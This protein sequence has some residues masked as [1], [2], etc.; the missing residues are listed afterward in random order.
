MSG[1][2]NKVLLRFAVFGFLIFSPL[3]SAENCSWLSWGPD[4]SGNISRKLCEKFKPSYITLYNNERSW[5]GNSLEGF[6]YSCRNSEVKK[7]AFKKKFFGQD[8]EGSSK[9]VGLYSDSFI[10]ALEVSDPEKAEE[11][12]KTRKKAFDEFVLDAVDR[13]YSRV[14]VYEMFLV[15]ELCRKSGQEQIECEKCLELTAKQAMMA[16]ADQ[17]AGEKKGRTPRRFVRRFCAEHKKR[18]AEIG[19][20]IFAAKDY[21]QSIQAK[22]RPALEQNPEIENWRDIDKPGSKAS[23]SSSMASDLRIFVGDEEEPFENLLL[24]IKRTQTDY[25]Y[26]AFDYLVANPSSD[27]ETLLSRRELVRRLVEDDELYEKTRDALAKMARS[28]S[29]VTSFLF[30]RHDCFTD[31]S[32]WLYPEGCTPL[33]IFEKLGDFGLTPFKRIMEAVNRNP[34]FITVGKPLRPLGDIWAVAAP[35]FFVLAGKRGLLK[36]VSDKGLLKGGKQFCKDKGDDIAD[37]YRLFISPSKEDVA[38]GKAKKLDSPNVERAKFVA[39]CFLWAF[40]GLQGALLTTR[41]TRNYLLG[42]ADSLDSLICSGANA[43]SI[44][45]SGVKTTPAVY[46]SAKKMALGLSD[47]VTSCRGLSALMA[48]NPVG[49]G[50][51]T[52]LDDLHDFVSGHNQEIKPILSKLESC[53]ASSSRGHILSTIREAYPIRWFF[54]KPLEAVGQI[55]AFVAA[56]TLVREHRK[57][58]GNGFCFADFRKTKTPG[59]RISDFW[60]PYINSEEA[61][62]NSLS[63]GWGDSEK[64][65]LL[66]GPNGGG[67][68]TLLRAVATCILMGQVFGISP[69]KSCSFSIYDLFDSC[70]ATK[71]KPADKRSLFMVQSDEVNKMRQVISAA[72]HAGKLAFVVI[73]EIYGGTGEES[74][75]PLGLAFGQEVTENPSSSVLLSSHFWNM[76]V[77][78]SMSNGIFKNFRVIKEKAEGDSGRIKLTYKLAEGRPD[79]FEDAVGIQVAQNCGTDEFFIGKAKELKQ[80]LYGAKKVSTTS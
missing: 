13:V 37:Q 16:L 24:R 54:S 23:L 6:I 56:A 72:N 58:G 19:S 2:Y 3:S 30:E 41:L 45:R 78:E 5:Y 36:Y 32:L 66:C 31:K 71:D 43:K 40:T 70:M 47:F 12:K 68:S 76:G 75:V 74:A 42:P 44:Y 1:F 77:L 26:A 53:K 14:C 18:G 57:K 34:L 52:L 65:M 64:H 27:Y 80:K 21:S 73:D 59:F 60:N 10:K 33:K 9:L 17:R 49:S 15:N 25:G 20:G 79:K 29:Q 39:K 63:L 22:H 61:V 48:Q 55:D 51:L 28:Q 46:K 11:Y 7:E 67:K 50:A 8:D 38:L 35:L 62:P 69:A 4:Y